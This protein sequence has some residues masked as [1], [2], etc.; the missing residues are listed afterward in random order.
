MSQ[1]IVKLSLVLVTKL[2]CYIFNYAKHEDC[3]YK[4]RSEFLML[5]KFCFAIFLGVAKAPRLILSLVKPHA[6]C[7]MYT[8]N[9]GF[10]SESLL[11]ALKRMA[12]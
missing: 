3:R 8:G 1:L 9:V 5:R 12:L 6:F 2:V 7:S 10:L 11:P 4:N